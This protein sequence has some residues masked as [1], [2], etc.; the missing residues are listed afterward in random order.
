MYHQPRMTAS[1]CSGQKAKTPGQ[2]TEVMP[3]LLR[4]QNIDALGFWRLCHSCPSA[5]ARN[6]ML[7]AELTFGP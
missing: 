2:G 5:I 6:H 4:T 7:V 1:V 3:L